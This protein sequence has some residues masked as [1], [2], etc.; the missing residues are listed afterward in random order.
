MEHILHSVF[1]LF[2]GFFGHFDQVVNLIA[3]LLVSFVDG[4]HALKYF[5]CGFGFL[6]NGLEF[7]DHLFYSFDGLIVVFELVLVEFLVD[8][9]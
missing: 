5:F 9:G 1:V 7:G 6:F 3:V 4:V 8:V 2:V